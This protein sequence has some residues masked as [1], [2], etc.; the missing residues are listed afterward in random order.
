MRWRQL[1]RTKKYFDN[2]VMKQIK[3]Q[4]I[5]SEFVKR[6]F[7]NHNFN[8]MRHCQFS[9]IWCVEIFELNTI[10]DWIVFIMTVFFSFAVIA[11]PELT[12]HLM[13]FENLSVCVELNVFFFKIMHVLVAVSVAAIITESMI[14]VLLWLNQHFEADIKR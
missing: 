2:S 12:I 14:T 10:L 4:K 3:Q 13:Y 8:I 5:S 7:F 1:L 6:G 11:N 9:L